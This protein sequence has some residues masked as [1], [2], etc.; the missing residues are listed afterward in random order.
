ML[1]MQERAKLGETWSHISRNHDALSSDYKNWI[2]HANERDHHAA[3]MAAEKLY[4]HVE[5][6]R[7][8]MHFLAADIEEITPFIELRAKRKAG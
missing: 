6:L 7:Q 3:Q 5:T 1:T 8:A 4:L 2:G